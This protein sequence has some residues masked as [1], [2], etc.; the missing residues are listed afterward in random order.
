MPLSVSRLDGA[1]RPGDVMTSA[2]VE[3]VDFFRVDASRKLHAARRSELGQY[4]TPAPVARLMAGM[5]ERHPREVRL[6]DAGAG[7]GSLTA[8]FVEAAIGWDTKPERIVATAY[9]VDPGLV[10]YL[11][12]SL[13]LCAEACRDAGIA[14]ESSVEGEDFIEAAVDMLDAGLFAKPLQLFNAAILNPPYRKIHSESEAR[15]LVRAVGVETS[16]LYTA[17]LALVVK[18]LEPGGELVAIT[19]RSFCNG[20]YF[21]PFRALFL[22]SMAINRVHVFE[23]RDR[24]F[25]D[26]EVL[27]ENVIMQAVRGE[28]QPHRVLVTANETPE[29]D[30]TV[31]RVAAEELV[32]PGD[33]GMFIRVVTDDL[34]VQVA[35]RMEGLP[36]TLAHLGL[37]VSTGRVVDFRAKPYL[38]AEPGARSAPLIYPG[39]FAS[40]FVEW[41]KL[42]TK[43]PNAIVVAEETRPLLM[44]AGFYVL[45]KRFSS[46]EERRRVVAAI[47]D[48]A[49]VDPGEVAFENHLNVYHRRGAGLP[50]LLAK[51]LAVFLNSTLVDVYFRQFSGHTQVNATDLRSFRYPEVAALERLGES[52]GAK[53][54]GQDEVDRLVR[55]GVFGV[56]TDPALARRKIDEA[57]SILKALGLPRAQQN[58]RS[59][60]TLLAL[61]ALKPEAPWSDAA[62]PLMGIRPMMDY[63]AENYGKKYAENTRE[64]VRRQTVHQ[65]LD[66]ALIV[67]NPD[68]PKR[69]INSG[70][71][72]YQIAPAALELLRACGSPV[73]DAKLAEYLERVPA[74]AKKYASERELR[75][76]PATLPTG[77]KV[78]L[79]PGGQNELV[80]RILE[81]FCPHFTPGGR[82]LYVGDT[83]E[84]WAVSDVA[85]LAALGVTFDQHGKMPDVVIHHVE[86]GWLVLVEAVTSH[87]PVDAKRRGELARLFAK[88]TAGIVYVTAFLDR[89]ALA[90][91]V[92]HISWETEVWV[93]DA[94][95]HLIHF[96]GERFL[97]PYPP[98]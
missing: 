65:F 3:P 52:V 50:E 83:D 2:L 15:R 17:F 78:T 30:M 49:R 93:A 19:P 21:K 72:V 81:D 47:Y 56:A 44:P 24:A 61:L 34:G 1:T 31:R 92:R 38:R 23:T 71:T 60:L 9:E 8:A 55:E 39:H 66:A 95:T 96:D 68:D 94:P 82:V 42:G 36:A 14:F 67:P 90:K 32:R 80:K 70:N 27:Q 20:P 10:P 62:S 69:P 98:R 37:E 77:Q 41:P 76:I 53:M 75:R 43:K 45:V 25:E 40:G 26:D 63:F 86:R 13:G 18:L 7:V 5:F 97:G 28:P 91:Y 74:L 88:S 6:L 73:W 58:Q 29:D 87:G 64:S 35:E 48:P 84:K 46:K 4:L 12:D 22:G 59:A 51:G 11:K 33:T 85:A 57:L 54:P 16:N 89:K 79:S